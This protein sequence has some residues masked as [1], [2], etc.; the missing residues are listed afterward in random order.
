MIHAITLPHKSSRKSLKLVPASYENNQLGIAGAGVKHVPERLAK[1]IKPQQLVARMAF[2]L[3]GL[4]PAMVYG[5]NDAIVAAG[6][7]TVGLFAGLVGNDQANTIAP[8]AQLLR[9]FVQN[10]E[11]TQHGVLGRNKV[12][13]YLGDL[14]EGAG[15]DADVVAFSK[16]YN[17]KQV[18][19]L[20]NRST[21]DAKEK[22][23]LLDPIANTD[24]KNL[25]VIYGYDTCGHLCVFQGWHNGCGIAYLKLYLKPM[26]LVVLKNYP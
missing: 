24:V 14:V 18:T 11:V 17:G 26:H 8:A 2:R 25:Q 7:G 22:F 1:T 23:I 19:L 16:T 13:E 4:E 15:D 3:L 20:Y 6:E 10:N 5:G 21:T 12:G 9:A